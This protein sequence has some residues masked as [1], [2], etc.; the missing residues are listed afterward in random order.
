MMCKRSIKHKLKSFRLNEGGNFAMFAAVLVPLCFAAGSIAVDFSNAISMKTRLQNAADGAALATASQLAA[1][2]ITVLEAKAYAENFFNGLMAGE[3]ANYDGFS[4][5]PVATITPIGSG[6]SLAWTV[7]VATIGT[8]MLTPMA[9]FV[10]KDK[11]DIKVSATSSSSLETNNPLSMMLVLDRSGSMGWNADGTSTPDYC[12]DGKKK[13]KKNDYSLCEKP[14]KL[15]ALKSAVS[16]MVTQFEQK[17]PKDM[18][19]RLG[20]VAYNSSVSASQQLELSWSKPDVATLTNSLVASGGTD[21]SGAIDWAYNELEKP[22]EKNE[23]QSR[24]GNK[25]PA[26]FI[27]F[28]TD[29]DNNETTADTA[30]KKT[31]DNAKAKGIDIFTVAF[32]APSRGQALLQYCATNADYYYNADNANDLLNAFQSIGEKASDLAVR[33]SS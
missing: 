6:T 10:G 4:A 25:D 24:S 31:C 15:D 7:K 19:V 3:A 14:S 26:K 8:Q 12:D 18:F 29:G 13:K 27:V 9:K 21:S 33:L 16:N 11:M 2:K 30:T 28:M 23:H 17:D 20:A 1:K 5:T 22:K 32:Q